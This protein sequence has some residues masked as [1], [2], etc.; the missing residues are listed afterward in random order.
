MIKKMLWFLFVALLLLTVAGGWEF[1]R[2]HERR[3]RY[4]YVGFQGELAKEPF[5]LFFRIL[6]S[7]SI[8]VEIR[9]NFLPSD[10]LPE[11]KNTLVFLQTPGWLLTDDQIESLLSWVRSGGSVLID[12]SFHTQ[13][14]RKQR[15]RLLNSLG[16][17]F[18][19]EAPA[20]NRNR[21]TQVQTC[22]KA[23][24]LYHRSDHAPVLFQ[25]PQ[26]LDAEAGTWQFYASNE[27]GWQLGWLT[28]G[29]GK[30]HF[31]AD[32]GFLHNDSLGQYDHLPFILD[33]F[34]VMTANEREWYQKRAKANASEA[35]VV[36]EEKIRMP[37][38]KPES[39][40]FFAFR[41]FPSIWQLLW[42]NFPAGMT[43]TVVLLIMWVWLKATR[44]GPIVRPLSVSRRQLMEHIQATGWFFWKHAAGREVLESQQRALLR[45]L[46][47]RYPG[48]EKIADTE[49]RVSFLSLHCGRDAR[50]IVEALSGLSDSP[51]TDEFLKKTRAIREVSET[52]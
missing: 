18:P 11:S 45:K 31:F 49:Q 20:S 23:Y 51:D 29:Q 38:E 26:T 46:E 24:T 1:Y 6:E 36:C 35:P 47:Q 14:G 37:S 28:F 8:A 19:D 17:E 27:W 39:L 12:A 41:R 10:T 42:E 43:L 33:F 9:E 7:R 30:V 32:T 5:A 2:T 48:L 13:S 50:V 16:L 40:L 44:S 4:E 3:E 52:L 15:H 22:E 34:D 25:Q 21:L